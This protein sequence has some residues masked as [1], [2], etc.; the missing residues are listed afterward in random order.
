MSV[1]SKTKASRTGMNRILAA[2][3]SGLVF[4]SSAAFAA[5]VKMDEGSKI[6]DHSSKVFR[7]DPDYKKTPYS[8]KAQ[9]DI[10][11]GKSA[12]ETPRPLL[13]LGRRQYDSGPFERGINLI[14]EKNLL[15]PGFAVYGD[16]RTAVAYNDN[17]GAEVGRVATRLNLD[18]DWKLTSTER[19]HAFMRP[20][21][22]GGNF[23]R[24]D[25]SADD[26][27]DGE[28]V[29]DG[30]LE[31]L[32]F[33]GDLGSIATGLGNDYSGFDLPFSVGLMPLLFQNG[34]WM[35]DAF[36]GLAFTI[37][38]RNSVA[39]DISNMDF[40]FFGGFDK[41][42]SPAITDGIG[43]QADHNV[44]IY[45]AAAFVEANQGYWEAGYARLDG[46]DG[47]DEFDF[48]NLTIAH[49]RR[50][51]ALLSNSARVIWSFGQNRDN[52]AQQTADGAIVLIENSLIT[53]KPS[54]LIP[55]FNFF[56]GFDRPQSAARDNGGILK[57]TGI[58]FETDGLTG[59]P[60]L[61]D[62]GHDT[63]GG[64]V[65]VNYLFAL[66]RQIVA[67]VA[68]LKVH[69]ADNESGRAAAGDQFGIGLRYQQPISRTWIIRGDAMAGFRDSADDLMGVR[70]EVRRK[71]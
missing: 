19:L 58:N 49:T 17:G 2:F 11:G 44:H 16:W 43:D 37:P 42:T 8:A 22:Q 10:Y 27:A 24:L 14:G 15:F 30:N 57:N 67:E 46:R 33:E 34:V 36:T 60:K 47:L 38:A 25:F 1:Q 7:P 50:F 21:D 45:G 23:T 66:D 59:F 4:A 9:R 31:T 29:G 35:E 26:E 56:A 69:G 68:A 32:F 39:L 54:T 61:D 64:A 12:V 28:F 41:V 62:T 40:T 13:E 48:H 53:S 70:F 52:N 63:W 20:L 3:A 51:G 18:I 65:G 6:V 55:Y 5:D 71:F